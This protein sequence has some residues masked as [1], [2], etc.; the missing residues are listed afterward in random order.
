MAVANIPV[1][2]GSSQSIGGVIRAEDVHL[3][4]PGVQTVGAI[5]QQAQW[6]LERTINTMYEIGS[7]KMYYVGDRRRGQAQFNR[8]VGGTQ[9]FREMVSQFG[10]LCKAASN[11]MTLSA[12]SAVCTSGSSGATGSA[13]PG[14]GEISYTLNGVTLQSLGASVSANDIVITETMGFMFVD[15]LYG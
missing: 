7:N 10:D 14:G 9:N 5:V 15:M 6:T 13:A 2:S 3:T 12:G 11:S 1:F 8:V 4:I